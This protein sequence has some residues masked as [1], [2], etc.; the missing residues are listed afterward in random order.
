VN[1]R[2]IENLILAF[3]V[4]IFIYY[5]VQALVI[6]DIFRFFVVLIPALIFSLLSVVIEYWLKITLPGGVKALVAL[7]LL[8]HVA[9]GINRFYWIFAPYYDKVAHVVSAMGLF[10][11]IFTFFVG[12]DYYGI[13]LKLR[14]VIVATLVITVIFFVAWEVTEFYIDVFAKTSYNNG[15]GD[16]IGDLI[17]DVIGVA[18]G[19]LVIAYYRS[20]IPPGKGIR[21]LFGKK[22]QGS[23]GNS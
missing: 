10:L 13:R 2:R 19:L 23:P 7:A 18:L 4:L 5:A 9:G 8:L 1:L 17:S 16:T 21:Y 20:K 14:T 11:V 3:F 12:L 6:G 22:G 15:M